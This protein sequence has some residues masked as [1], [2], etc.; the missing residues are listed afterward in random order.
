MDVQ[1]TRGRNVTYVSLQKT[2]GETHLYIMDLGDGL[3]TPVGEIGS[4]R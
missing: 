4:D 2:S 3:L 1:T